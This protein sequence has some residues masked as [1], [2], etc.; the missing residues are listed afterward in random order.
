MAVAKGDSLPV[1][2]LREAAPY[3][4]RPFTPDAVKWKVQTVFGG[5]SG[6]LIVAYID[7]R[8]V[9]ERLNAVIPDK[10]GASF[11]PIDG[12]KL[13]WCDLEVDDVIRSDVGESTKGMSK[14]L[15]SDALKRAAVHFGVGV[16]IYALP[17]VRWMAREVG[18][19]L[20][21]QKVAQKDSLVLTDAGHKRL[22]AGYET[23][24]EKVGVP[25]F[26]EPLDHGDVIGMF[27]GETQAED[28]APEPDLPDETP[29]K[30]LDDEKAKTQ[31]AAI[32]AAYKR[33]LTVG[34]Q[35]PKHRHESYVR[36][37]AS[38]DDLAKLLAFYEGEF[39][40]LSGRG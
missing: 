30:P 24:L 11:R 9:I 16:S 7:A 33:Y 12:S 20:R 5:A 10:W 32:E 15:V 25:K 36:S 35:T 28:V 6:C 26:G 22:R 37:A 18:D 19:A 1:G 21:P 14:D 23:W 40:R 27:E 34:G 3:L 13:I 31:R 4:R 29:A 38:H 2:T 17:Q 8:L 39:N